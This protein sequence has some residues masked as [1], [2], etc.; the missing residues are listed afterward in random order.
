[1][2]AL[3]LWVGAAAAYALAMAR[4]PRVAA[5]ALAARRR[6]Q[7]LLLLEHACLLLLLVSGLLLMRHRGWGL[8][9]A[10]WLMAKLGLVAF[11]VVPLEAFHVWIARGLRQTPSPPFSKDLARGLAVQEM[12]ATLAVPLLGTALPLLLWLSLARPF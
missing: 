9:H 12:I 1:V 2:A 4:T 6:L 11:L 3:A 5:A 7:P 8:G 10:R